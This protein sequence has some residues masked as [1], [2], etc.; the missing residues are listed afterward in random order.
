V[1]HEVHEAIAYHLEVTHVLGTRKYFGLPSMIG[2]SKKS[3]FKFI[4][5][6]IWRKIIFWS[7][8]YLSQAGRKVMIKSILQSIPTY[9]MSVFLLPNTL[10]D[11]IEKMINSF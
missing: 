9:E 10:I 11:E 2:K 7:S 3:T 1:T 6:K 4:M 5:D 8:R